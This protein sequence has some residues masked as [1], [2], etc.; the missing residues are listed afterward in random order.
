[1]AQVTVETA[2]GGGLDL[3]PSSCEVGTGTAGLISWHDGV[4]GPK[5]R[6]ALSS[7]ASE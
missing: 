6:P 5:S 3:P 4:A 2:Y 1:M 7:A